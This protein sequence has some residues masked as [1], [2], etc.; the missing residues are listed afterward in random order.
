[1]VDAPPHGTGPIKGRRCVAIFSVITGWVPRVWRYRQ[2]SGTHLEKQS[3]S[4]I[5]V[6]EFSLSIS[7]ASHQLRVAHQVLQVEHLGIRIGLT[8]RGS[9]E[10]GL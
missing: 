10:Q 7:P 4:L 6:D 5:P 2:F 1:M 9:F 8:S 3:V